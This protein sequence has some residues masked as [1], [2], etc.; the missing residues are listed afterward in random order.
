MDIASILTKRYTAKAFDPDRKIDPAIVAQIEML[1][2]YSPSSTNFQPWHFIIAET[3]QG[4][5]R[6]AKATVGRYAFNSE[7]I[8]KASH[9]VVLCARATIQDQDL[10]AVLS[11]EDKDGRFADPQAKETQH[12]GRS[13]FVN[14]HRFELRDAAHW[15]DK[16]V[17]LA[18]GFLL[19]GAATLGVDA[20]PIEGFDQ[21]ALDEELGLRSQNLNSTVIVALGYHSDADFNANL[22]KSRLP[23]DA[24]L[25]KI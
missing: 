12:Q 20:C 9:V 5:A 21:V 3:E 13:Y 6:V 24:V 10:A 16:Q 19:L 4:K 15:M 22:P 7:K 8:T 18:L 1:L 23:A 25:T 11:Q 14:R 2:R 17:Y